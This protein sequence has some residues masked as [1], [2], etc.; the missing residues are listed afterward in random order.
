MGWQDLAR[1]DLTVGLKLVRAGSSGADH[2]TTLSRSPSADPA[3]GRRSLVPIC[4]GD[5][6]VDVVT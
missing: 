4:R 6:T 1:S 3:G 5:Q 2:S